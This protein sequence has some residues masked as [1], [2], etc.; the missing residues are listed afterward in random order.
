MARKPDP[1][2]RDRILSVASRLFQEHGPDGVGLQ[3][4]IDECG[5]GKNLLYREFGS[6]DD[7]VVAYLERCR[8]EWDDLV[9]KAAQP[10]HEDPAGQLVAIVGAVAERSATPGFRGCPL[11]NSLP[12][13]PDDGHPA[14]RVILDFHMAWRAHLR[15]LAERTGARDPRTLADKIMLL[16]DGLHASGP[17]L[18][19][20][21]AGEA[22]VAF[23]K[24][25][26]IAA[27]GDRQG[28]LQRSSELV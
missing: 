19:E 9:E 10:L 17:M 8:Q 2:A 20:E 27:L 13:F 26:V 25:A 22:A 23:A 16:I 14:R 5:C 28:R 24:E 1:G 11:R 6:K 4:I 18:G 12:S 7:L 21:G 15:D 3:Q